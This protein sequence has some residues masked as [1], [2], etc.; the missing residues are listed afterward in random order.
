MQDLLRLAD[1]MFHRT[2]R[3]K[4][5]SSSKEAGT[6]IGQLVSLSKQGVQDAA[7]RL[8]GMPGMP[9]VCTIVVNYD[10]SNPTLM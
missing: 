3:K 1:S 6:V 2:E 5:C 7:D 9:K 4:G 10:P 8:K